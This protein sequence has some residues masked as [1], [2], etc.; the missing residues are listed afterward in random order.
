MA[1][2]SKSICGVEFGREHVSV[3][4]YLPEERTVSGL[5]IKPFD[6]DDGSWFENI[7][8]E[9]KS[10]AAT[11]HLKKERCVCALP[12]DRVIIKRLALDKGEASDL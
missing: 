3:V 6:A 9:F 4:R 8:T 7:S 2:K 1:G 11:M 12:H 5:A 10:I